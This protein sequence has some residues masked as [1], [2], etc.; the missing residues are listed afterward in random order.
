LGFQKEDL[1]LL[2]DPEVITDESKEKKA[3]Q[4]SGAIYHSVDAKTQDTSAGQKA[5]V[6]NTFYSFFRNLS[7]SFLA[8]AIMNL[9]AMLLKYLDPRWSTVLLIIFNLTLAAIFFIRAKERG[10]RYVKG[11]FWSYF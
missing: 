5:H 7:L 6:Q 4:L 11:L 9:L 2:L 1:S 3:M 8:L 10:E